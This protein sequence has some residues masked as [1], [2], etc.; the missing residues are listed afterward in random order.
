MRY[1]LTELVAVSVLVLALVIDLIFGDPAPWK[2]MKRYQKL[3]ITIWMGKLVKA[4][5][6]YFKNPNPRNEKRNG[7]LLALIVIIA[8][9]APV[10]SGVGSGL[11]P[12]LL[13]VPS[14]CPI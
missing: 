11:A 1:I 8:F 14:N 7:I 5:E 6:P 4:L 3:H 13:L 10:Y 9:T 2:P 12:G